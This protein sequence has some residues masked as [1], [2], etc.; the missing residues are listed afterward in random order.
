MKKV[1]VVF[2]LLFL[3]LISCDKNII[4]EDVPQDFKNV[5]ENGSETVFSYPPVESLP[6][7]NERGVKRHRIVEIPDDFAFSERFSENEMVHLNLF[8]DIS[9]HGKIDRINKNVNG[10][11]SIRARIKEYPLSY[12]LISTTN[13]KTLA[14]LSIPEENTFYQIQYVPGIDEHIV[15]EFDTDLMEKVEG[16]EPVIPAGFDIELSETKPVLMAGDPLSL[17]TVT[18]LIVYTS[19]ARSW[20]DSSGGGIEN[21]IAQTMELSQLSLD[22]SNTITTL[23]LVHSEEISNYT[24]SDIYTDFHRLRYHELF[25]PYK[26]EFDTGGYYLDYIHDLRNEYGA[27][28]V[29]M[30]RKFTSGLDTAGGLAALPNASGEDWKGF[31][32]TSVQYLISTVNFIH[33]VGHNFGCNHAKEI[34]GAGT[35]SYSQ[36]WRWTGTDGKQYACNHGGGTGY[37]QIFSFSNPDIN[38]QGAPTG[39]A[40]DGDNARTVREMKHALASYRIPYEEALDLPFLKFTSGGLRKWYGQTL[41]KQDGVDAVRNEKIKDSTDTWIQTTVRWPR[42]VEIFLESKFRTKYVC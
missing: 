5:I 38:Y 12:F 1:S 13:G 23:E 11:V 30:V 19:E 31:T 26:Q 6:L 40:V 36:G 7:K 9:L 20:A 24:Q 28:L 41:I 3:F 10:T 2:L 15:M 14:I 4:Y 17:A 33:E 32:A 35:F 27:D 37:I 25:D 29:S 21:V 42:R 8:D 39:D 34:G 22:D 18:V 16:G